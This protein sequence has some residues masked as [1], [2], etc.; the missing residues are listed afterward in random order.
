MERSHEKL[1]TLADRGHALFCVSLGFSNAERYSH[2]EIKRSITKNR[3][4]NKVVSSS[5]AKKNYYT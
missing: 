1:S 3:T 5:V 4:E 2:I